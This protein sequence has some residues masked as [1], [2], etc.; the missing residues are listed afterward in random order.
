MENIYDEGL[1]KDLEIIFHEKSF[2]YESTIESNSESSPLVIFHSHSINTY[3]I[4]A[5]INSSNIYVLAIYSPVY[6]MQY[7][8]GNYTHQNLEMVMKAIETFRL[9]II[10]I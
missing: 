10:N 8:D 5:K 1:I 2:K 7:Y 3:I 9:K 6:K 4:V